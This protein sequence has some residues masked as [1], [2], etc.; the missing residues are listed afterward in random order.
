[1]KSNIKNDFYK[2]NMLKIL[3][4]SFFLG[5]CSSSLLENGDSEQ[6]ALIP[7][8]EMKQGAGVF[9]GAKGAFYV[10]DPN[11][12]T[13]QQNEVTPTTSNQNS[14]SNMNLNETSKVL[15]DKI[16]QLEKDQI[17]LELLKRKVDKKIQAQ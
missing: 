4:V 1:M 9:S 7:A 15:D 8:D 2:V 10:I 3:A 12:K 17:E 11:K 6:L 5:G 13:K 16:K 14:V